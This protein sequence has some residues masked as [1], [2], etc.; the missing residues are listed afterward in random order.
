MFDDDNISRLERLANLKLDG[1]ERELFVEYAG[2]LTTR[3]Q[4]IEAACS[5]PTGE[6]QQLPGPLEHTLGSDLSPQTLPE[7]Q[8]ELEKDRLVRELF[9]APLL[10]HSR[11]DDLDP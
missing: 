6:G 2:Y 11:D 10:A 3:L 4:E 9:R 7:D 1:E 8:V 5:S